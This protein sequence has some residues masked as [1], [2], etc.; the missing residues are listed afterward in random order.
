MSATIEARATW[1]G[2]FATDVRA[3]GHELRVDEP[4]GTGTD[5]G[6]MPTEVFIASVASCFCLA[7]AHVAGKRGIETPALEV[8]V[9]AERAGTE[10]RYGRMTVTAAAAMDGATLDLLVERARHVC[11]V[12]NTLAAG[13][14]VEYRSAMIDE[15]SPK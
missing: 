9:R 7:V 11:W 12:S 3:R 15:H 1:R 4:A 13:I 6:M 2:G 10:L 5:T 14:V 8:T